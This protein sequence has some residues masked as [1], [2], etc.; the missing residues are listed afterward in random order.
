MASGVWFKR[1]RKGFAEVLK[2]DGVRQDLESRA[3]R[4]RSKAQASVADEGVEVRSDSYVGRSRAGATVWG[5]P[6][7]IEMDERT[8][9]SAIDAAG[10]G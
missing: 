5:V 2:S 10:G 4:V 1:D 8:L 9:G 3:D 7:R 6:M